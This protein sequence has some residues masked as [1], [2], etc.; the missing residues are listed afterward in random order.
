MCGNRLRIG[1][2]PIQFTAQFHGHFH[3][4]SM[5]MNFMLLRS[6]TILRRRAGL[7]VKPMQI[8]ALKIFG[9]VDA[10]RKLRKRLGDGY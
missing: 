6:M 3:Q 1:V 7:H 4:F 8:G 10:G 5:F 2:Q 9:C